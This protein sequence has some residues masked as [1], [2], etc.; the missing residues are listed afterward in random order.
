M[1]QYIFFIGFF[2]VFSVAISQQKKEDTK[3]PINQFFTKSLVENFN[4]FPLNFQYY[5]LKNYTA[6][7][8][9]FELEDGDYKD[10]RTPETIYNFGLATQGI[11]KN[12][13]NL[14]FFGDISIAKTFY[15]N[16]KWNL[17]YQ[18]PE[19]GIMNDPHYFGVPKA[20]DWNNQEYNINGGFIIPL[21]KK[22]SLL[23]KVQYC[24]SNKYRTK[25]DPRPE[26]IYN[27]LNFNVGGSYNLN[28][29]H[30]LKAAFS[31]GYTHVNNDITFSNNNKNTPSNY[32]IYVKWFAGYGSLSSPFKN[33]TQRRMTHS[34]INLGYSFTNK[35]INLMADVEYSNNNQITYKNSGIINSHDKSNYLATYTPKKIETNLLLIYQLETYKTLKININGYTENADNFWESKGGKSYSSN[36][37]NISAAIA[38]L[39]TYSNNRFLD[40]GLTT[41]LY[42][43]KQHDALA[44]TTSN[45]TNIN[46]QSYILRAF[47]L[48]KTV[49]LS[50]YFKN[51]VK[52][53]LSNTYI[54]GNKND[55]NNIKE[56]DFAGYVQRDFYNE[57]IIPNTELYST[58]QLHL[59]LGT[60]IQL[61]TKK[62]YN[63]NLKAEGGINLPLQQMQHFKNQNPSRFNA[64]AS[65]TLNY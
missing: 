42:E 3:D 33:S 46:I 29:T 35:A 9:Y 6:S 31:Y 34:K 60:L 26:I 25:L 59:N 52:F 13:K 38:Y 30:H 58:N 28:K 14:L 15:K 49:T 5:T 19:R 54:Q 63:I 48:S 53:N 16:L 64:I 39:K 23:T 27:N 62:V 51:T 40:L 32:D 21:T 24:L 2:S 7:S 45:Y 56:N 55:F 22:I 43:I 50:P 18:L 4:K 17:S 47:P 44:K 36:Q 1:K 12:K 57:V 61:S 20:G 41:G 11:Y 37:N 8:L 65:L 10:G